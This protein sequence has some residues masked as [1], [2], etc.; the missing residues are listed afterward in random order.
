VAVGL[1]DAM[2]GPPTQMGIFERAK[3]TSMR[4]TD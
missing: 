4:K 1:E 3:E 2:L